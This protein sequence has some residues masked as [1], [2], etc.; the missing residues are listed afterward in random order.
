[1]SENF[2]DVSRQLTDSLLDVCGESRE[3][4]FMNKGYWNSDGN[5]QYIRNN[6]SAWDA[7]YDTTL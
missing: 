1:M 4:W 6:R 2:K 5:A 7:L 3:H